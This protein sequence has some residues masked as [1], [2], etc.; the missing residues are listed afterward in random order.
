[1]KYS[2]IEW[3]DHTWNPVTGCTKISAGCKNCY[4]ETLSKRKF[5]EWKNRSFSEIILKYSKL[6]EPFSLRKPSKIFIV[7][8][9]LA[10]LLYMLIEQMPNKVKKLW[11]LTPSE[12]QP[13]FNDLGIAFDPD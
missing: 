9:P 5:G 11:P 1:M 12:L 4:A 10:I 7:G 6:K 2:E 13:L 3:T 8:Q